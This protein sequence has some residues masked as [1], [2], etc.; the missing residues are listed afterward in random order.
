MVRSTPFR[1]DTVKLKKNR[2]D[3]EMENIFTKIAH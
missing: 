1:K 2:S 3:L